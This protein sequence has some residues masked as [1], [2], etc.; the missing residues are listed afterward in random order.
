[1]GISV[2][3]DTRLKPAY[4]GGK[5]MYKNDNL[6]G[7]IVRDLRKKGRIEPY[8]EGPTSSRFGVSANEWEEQIKPALSSRTSVQERSERFIEALIIPHLYPYLPR[9]DDGDTATSV[10][11][12][13]YFEDR[14]H[15]LYGGN[16]DI[17]GLANV[18]WHDAVDHWD[19]RSFRPLA[20]L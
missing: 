12:E 15:R 8:K 18:D 14:G 4:Q 19:S 17:G 20:V 7:P 11:Y 9:K 13:E 16:S 10:W 1:M 6:C 5:Q 3:I 2:L